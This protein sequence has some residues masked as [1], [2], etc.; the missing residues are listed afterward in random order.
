MVQ[1]GDDP[2][3][4]ARRMVIFVSEDVDLADPHALTLANDVFKAV[5]TIGYPEY[6]INLVHGVCYL[7]QAPKSR[8]SYYAYLAAEQGWGTCQYH[9]TFVM[10][11]PSL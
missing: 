2:I 10:L 5:Q 9:L 11:Q 6:S 4:I 1:T 7:A 8:A 3:F